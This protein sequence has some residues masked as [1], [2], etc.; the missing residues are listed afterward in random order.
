MCKRRKG[1]GLA[2]QITMSSGLLV[3]VYFNIFLHILHQE[4]PPE[5]LVPAKVMRTSLYTADF[6]ILDSDMKLW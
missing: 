3:E 6:N 1:K 2:L 4:H 5:T